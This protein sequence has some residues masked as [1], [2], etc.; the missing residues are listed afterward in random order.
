MNSDT[1]YKEGNHDDFITYLFSGHMILMRI[2]VTPDNIAIAQALFDRL[3]SDN[4]DSILCPYI[5]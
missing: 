1:I 4:D 5:I 2:Y 3:V